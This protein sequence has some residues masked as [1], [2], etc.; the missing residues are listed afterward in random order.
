MALSIRKIAHRARRLLR[1]AATESD[2]AKRI[3][4]LCPEEKT[5]VLP[6]IY[7]RNNLQRI[8]GTAPQENLQSELSRLSGGY[9][10]WRATIAF[11][12][13]DV[14]LED[15]SFYCRGW[16]ARVSERPSR[17]PGGVPVEMYEAALS[18]T[19]QGSAYFSV[20]V[21]DDLTM[22][23]EA[24]K[25][26]TP[27]TVARVLYKDEPYYAD[28]LQVQPQPL[29]RARFKRFVFLHDLGQNSSKRR[30]YEELR[31][32]LRKRHPTEGAERVFIRRGSSGAARV[33][34]GAGAV[35][36]LV[37]EEALAEILS[38]D[39]FVVI[40]PEKE[41]TQVIAQACAGAQIV[42]GVEGS[43]MIH[44]FMAMRQ[45]GA[46]MTMVPPY[47]FITWFKELTDCIGARYGT[48]VG[49]AADGGFGIDPDELRRLVD[50][51]ERELAQP[52]CHPHT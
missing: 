38:R 40:D 52:T 15:G 37:N 22:Y 13:E 20:W 12:M 14:V 2:I 45:N 5:Y 7:D 18:T 41:P 24:E 42:L 33:P 16:R 44:G 39:G 25:L 43:H 1:M 49:T 48:I 17:W 4:I 28:V 3:E 6:T 23:L 50:R 30:R 35:R 19:W 34:E 27:V 31:S 47:R 26:G 9:T 10:K 29:I 21:T 51:V 11:H 36:R 8:T 46:I 32:R